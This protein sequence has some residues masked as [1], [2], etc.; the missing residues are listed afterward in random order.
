M[1]LDLVSSG[2]K[3][4][5]GAGGVGRLTQRSWDRDAAAHRAVGDPIELV[6]HARVRLLGRFSDA[7]DRLADQ[8]LQEMDAME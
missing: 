1:G 8:H 2:L 3:R 6:G 4:D 7:L 5:G